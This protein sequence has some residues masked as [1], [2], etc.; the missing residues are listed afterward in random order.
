MHETSKSQ[1]LE[2][3][4]VQIYSLGDRQNIYGQCNRGTGSVK[5]FFQDRPTYESESLGQTITYI[6]NDP[7]LVELSAF[8]IDQVDPRKL[9][10]GVGIDYKVSVDLIYCGRDLLDRK[11]KNSHA[12]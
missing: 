3:I 6:E 2:G 1:R 9:L 10:G 7:G 4:S 11:N 5:A 12:R 8:A